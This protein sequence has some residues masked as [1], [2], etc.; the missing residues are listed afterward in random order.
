MVL[1]ADD[2]AAG[3]NLLQIKDWW[4]EVL[5]FCR[6]FGHLFNPALT[7]LAATQE[8]LFP[9]HLIFDGTGI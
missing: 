1:Y 4:S 2:A 9:A 3:G 5:S 6:H 7:W 8:H